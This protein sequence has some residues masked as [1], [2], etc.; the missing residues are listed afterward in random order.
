MFLRQKHVVNSL[1]KLAPDFPSLADRIAEPHP[2]MN[3][4]A[5]AFT[6]RE[7]SSNILPFPV[8]R[9]YLLFGAKL[10]SLLRRHVFK[11]ISFYS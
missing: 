9:F 4:K 11:I 7:K 1:M 2:V 5:A 8:A 6:V 10:R 3:I